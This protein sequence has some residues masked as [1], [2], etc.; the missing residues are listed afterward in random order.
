MSAP[1]SWCWVGVGPED[2]HG[3]EGEPQ[4]A[5]AGEQA[6]QLRLVDDLADELGCAGA[7][8]DRHA[9]E[10]CGEAL[11]D[12][13]AHRDPDPQGRFHVEWRVR[14][15]CVTAHH[16][17]AGFTQDD[18]CRRPGGARVRLGRFDECEVRRVDG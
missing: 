9:I 16:A 7:W 11:A 15:A 13:L 2:V 5:D 10:G 12:T 4:V 8:Y 1:F 17:G 6:V 18:W 3:L 14:P